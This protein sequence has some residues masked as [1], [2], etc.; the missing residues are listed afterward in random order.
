MAG[1]LSACTAP[2]HTSTP[3]AGIAGRYLTPETGVVLRASHTPC[4]GTTGD[5]EPQGSRLGTGRPEHDARLP[6][7]LCCKRR[8]ASFFSP[9]DSLCPR[10]PGTKLPLSPCWERY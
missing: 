10:E 3:G 8:K 5:E 9:G 2:L 7:N 6:A 1:L 4:H